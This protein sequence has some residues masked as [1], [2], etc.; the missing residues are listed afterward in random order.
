[1]ANPFTEKLAASLAAGTFVRLV[2]TRPVMPQPGLEKVL[3]RL[4][5][6]RAGWRL[7]LTYR[8]RQRDLTRHIAL[9]DAVPLAEGFRAG[10]LATTAGD[11][12]WTGRRLIAHAP[13]TTTAPDRSH[14]RPKPSRLDDTARPWLTALGIL[15]TAGKVRASMSAKHR[16]IQRYLEIFSHLAAHLEIRS[17]ADLGAGKG[18]L[19]FA[20][21]HW[22]KKP[23][24]VLGVDARADL[25]EQ[26]NRLARQIGAEGLEFVT[27]TIADVELPAVDAFIAL[28]ACDTATDDAIR[29]GVRAGA[30]LILVA[31]C[32][33][34]QLRPQLGAPPPLAPVLAHGIMAERMAEWVTDGLRALALEWA[35]YRTQLMEFVGSEHTPKNLLLVGRRVRPP[36][37]EPAARQRYEALKAYFGIARHALDGLGSD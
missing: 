34:R 37:S 23:V 32:C 35:G 14:D 17:V 25:V 11:W 12:Q 18:Y 4:V 1:M 33:H 3:G 8:Y 36:C 2:L 24:R 13:A 21:W 15:D 27:G 26:A 28:H 5:Q 20:L 16:Q 22:L 31:P 19:T 10:W 9:A 7:L 6:V 29:R 30:Q